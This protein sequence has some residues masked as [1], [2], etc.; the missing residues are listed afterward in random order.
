MKNDGKKNSYINGLMSQEVV[1]KKK[2]KNRQGFANIPNF[3]AGAVICTGELVVWKWQPVQTKLGNHVTLRR[4]FGTNDC[5]Y[6][7]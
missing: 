5:A 2:E 3:S 6:L 7:L 4:V 1:T